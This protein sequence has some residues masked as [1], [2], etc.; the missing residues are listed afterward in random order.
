MK[1]DSIV[2]F[3]K[4]WLLCFA[5]T[6]AVGTGTWAVPQEPVLMAIEIG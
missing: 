3:V 5:M 6:V 1:N 2:T 4:K